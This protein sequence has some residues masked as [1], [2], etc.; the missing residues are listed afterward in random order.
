M[1]TR[2]AASVD[3]QGASQTSKQR[4]FFQ[5]L[6]SYVVKFWP[7]AAKDYLHQG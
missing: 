5:T 2:L 4:F 3:Q 6:L 1:S 7:S